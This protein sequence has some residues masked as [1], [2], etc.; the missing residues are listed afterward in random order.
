MLTVLGKLKIWSGVFKSVLRKQ[1]LAGAHRFPPLLNPAALLILFEYLT[2]RP[3]S[4]AVL[5]S[6][7]ICFMNDTMP[8]S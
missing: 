2:G 6:F 5:T 7:L 1:C 4:Q 8:S 3:F